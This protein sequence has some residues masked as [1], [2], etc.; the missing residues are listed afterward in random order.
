[1]PPLT[2]VGVEVEVEVEVEVG[3]MVVTKP[4][5]KT[6]TRI[7]MNYSLTA[8]VAIPALTEA[9]VNI[10]VKVEVEVE[11]QTKDLPPSVHPPFA[12]L[13]QCGKGSSLRM[14]PLGADQFFY[15]P[16]RP[17]P[18]TPA[19]FSQATAPSPSA[20]QQPGGQQPG[21]LNGTGTFTFRQ[22]LEQT[23]NQISPQ[24]PPNTGAPVFAV[25]TQQEEFPHAKQEEDQEDVEMS[26]VDSQ[27]TVAP[28][29]APTPASKRPGL[30]A[31]RW[32]PENAMCNS[33]NN[34]AENRQAP[35]AENPTIVKSGISQ[36]FGLEVS[37]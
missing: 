13:A 12:T 1:M 4:R 30:A 28:N 26:G 9:E 8:E 17:L 2:E 34:K 23:T 7:N 33:G 15:Q 11:V 31:S 18:S 36:G 22:P 20:V 27:S 14:I 29:S 37:R 16:Q 19:T 3:I 5:R 35:L 6:S 24:E 32:N 21:S 25:T 10:E